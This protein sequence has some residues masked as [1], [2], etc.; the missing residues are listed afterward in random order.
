MWWYIAFSIIF[1]VY[2]IDLLFLFVASLFA[3]VTEHFVPTLSTAA[4]LQH[5]KQ[6]KRLTAKEQQQQAAAKAQIA[7]NKDAKQDLSIV[8]D[9]RAGQVCRKHHSMLFQQRLSS[10]H[11]NMP[12][13]LQDCLLQCK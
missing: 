11:S 6:Q 10:G 12:D 13:A 1:T 5:K 7:A 8:V 9:T 3:A 4:T 2:A